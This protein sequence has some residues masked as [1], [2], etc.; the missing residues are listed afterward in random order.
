[1]TQPSWH[2]KL[3]TWGDNS[4]CESEQALTGPSQAFGSEFHFERNYNWTY[5]ISL[6]CKIYLSSLTSSQWFSLD[7][8]KTLPTSLSTLLYLT[9]R[10][11]FLYLSHLGWS[12][13]ASLKPRLLENV[14]SPL[15]LSSCPQI[16][17]LVLHSLSQNA[18]LKWWLKPCD[19]HRFVQI[20]RS[21]LPWPYLTKCPFNHKSS[22]GLLFQSSSR[23]HQSPCVILFH[24]PTEASFQRF[25]GFTQKA[26][27]RC[28]YKWSG[29]G[30]GSDRLVAQEF[31]YFPLSRE[32]LYQIIKQTMS[33]H[34]PNT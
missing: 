5:G 4:P 19:W 30:F 26:A 18:E 34:T 31:S 20:R 3:T 23:A 21:C 6:K 22:P 11:Q 7:Q 28:L 14:W 32:N 24:Y 15:I 29:V 17:V 25:H 1:M 10:H 9:L 33:L 16:Q 8:R 12:L 27:S 2:T 13:C